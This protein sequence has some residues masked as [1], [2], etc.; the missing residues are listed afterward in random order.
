MKTGAFKRLFTVII[1]LF[2]KFFGYNVQQERNSESDVH[3]ILYR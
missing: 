3:T 1:G 2:D